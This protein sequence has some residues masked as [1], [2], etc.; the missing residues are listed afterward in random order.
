[1]TAAVLFVLVNE[2]NLNSNNIYEIYF[3]K[4]LN[5]AYL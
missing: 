5:A 4:L 2:Q 3:I 1:M